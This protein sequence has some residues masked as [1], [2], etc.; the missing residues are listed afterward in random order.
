MTKS[1]RATP[2][3]LS[4]L[5]MAV[6]AACISV[7][8][9][10]VLFE[11]D[12]ST[13]TV[14]DM[15]EIKGPAMTTA[16]PVVDLGDPDLNVALEQ[17]GWVQIAGDDGELS[18]Q[19][20]FDHLDPDPGDLPTHWMRMQRPQV[21]LFLNGGRTVTLTGRTLEAYA[22]KRALEQGTLDGNV[23]IRLFEPEDGSDAIPDIETTPPSM[24]VRTGMATFDNLAGR[25]E[26]PGDITATSAMERMSGRELLVLLNNRDDRIE[27]LRLAQVD[28]LMLQ[29]RSMEDST[30]ARAWQGAPYQGAPANRPLV[31]LT[32]TAAAQPKPTPSD[33][34]SIAFYRVH[35]EHNVRIEQEDQAGRRL[36][37]GD[38]I[39]VIFSMQNAQGGS[40]SRIADRSHTP[41]RLQSAA[42]GIPGGITPTLAGLALATMPQ[43]Q[44]SPG[45]RPT[46]EP[47]EILVTCDG[48]LTMVPL[49]D[50]EQRPPSRGDTRLELRGSPVRLLDTSDRIGALCDRL[51]YRSETER[52]DLLAQPGKQVT[53]MTDDVWMRA[54]NLWAEMDT[55][56]AGSSD[57]A[58]SA[59]MLASSPLTAALQD[60]QAAQIDPEAPGSLEQDLTIEWTKGVSVRFEP[61]GASG[62]G[63]MKF[64]Q[65]NGNVKVRTPDGDI[66][67]QSLEMQFIPDRTGKA[68]PERFVATGNVRAHN[69]DQ[70]LWADTLVATLDEAEPLPDAGDAA[71]EPAA[72]TGAQDLMADA[73]V[74]DF[75]ANGDVQVLLADG[76]RA[77]AD[78]LEGDAQQEQ[79]VLKGDNIVVARADLLIEHGTQV[80]IERK[81]GTAD[82]PGG[83]LARLLARPIDVTQDRR[84]QRPTVPAPTKTI[85]RVVTMRATWNDAMTFDSNFADG[86][87]SLDLAG[88]VSIVAQQQ[89]TERASL[90]GQS[91]RLEFASIADSAKTS[92]QTNAPKTPAPRNAAGGFAGEGRV[93]SKLIATGTARLER[94]TW[95][96]KDRTRTPEIIYIGGERVIWD[97]IKTS[98]S[99][100]GEGDFVTRQPAWA[101]REGDGPFRGPGIARFTWDNRLDMVREPDER[102]HIVMQGMVEGLWK[103]AQGPDDIATLSADAVTA[104]TRRDTEAVDPPVPG[105][106]PASPASVLDFDGDASIE[107]VT[108]I[109]RVFL[110]TPTR[111]ADA[112]KLNYNTRTGI[113]RLEGRPGHPVAIVNEGAPLP[114]RAT[115][116]IWNMDPAIDTITLQ[117]PRGSGSR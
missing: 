14:S 67:A 91:L 42:G 70:T 111:R 76:A 36:A 97:D 65:F 27:F 89:P 29:E 101:A 39:D 24:I 44:P 82:W 106:P 62:S 81:A 50:G 31:Q 102:F 28:W 47:G 26:C 52:V 96:T 57:T 87:G 71:A 59:V 25:I 20:R 15:P 21:Q 4:K 117:S 10:I 94:R 61:G 22:P 53:V 3:G 114:V 8:V 104:V 95:P 13:T 85:P 11:P 38:T 66:D 92:G 41:F 69:V 2:A 93:L 46:P 43:A 55:G 113:A 110:A 64:V 73:R 34:S 116:M 63:Q 103:G 58:G 33:P 37:I 108:A 12:A 19:Y 99:V 100:E 17:G 54:D 9:L 74:R 112:D 78:T 86:A 16:P 35:M 72:E 60:E 109:G 84:I 80:T 5:V 49:P 75:D 107:L 1:N 77:F 45:N 115:A 98:A 51:E 6:A 7:L 32:S 18:Q 105:T 56:I 79:V 40:P 68:R 83:G 48:P 23:I 30:S 90:G 88:D